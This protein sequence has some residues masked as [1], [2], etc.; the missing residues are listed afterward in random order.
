MFITGQTNNQATLTFSDGVNNDPVVL[1]ELFLNAASYTVPTKENATFIGYAYT[2][3]A[4]E[5]DISSTAQITYNTVKDH[6]AEGAVVLYP[7]FENVVYDLVVYVYLGNSSYN[8]QEE[9]FNALKAAFNAE[10]PDAKINW[11]SVYGVKNDVFC[12]N[13]T[14]GNADVMIGG[15]A[16]TNTF[17]EDYQKVILDTTSLFNDKTRYIGVVSGHED[18]ALAVAL[19]EYV[20]ATNPPATT[21][22][23]PETTPEG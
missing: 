5:A 20:L 1:S 10:K 14:N 21:P 11:V 18:N 13:A 7:V 3:N 15:K 9:E 23:E 12:S 22:E 2:E 4:T 16:M 19:Y 6:L 8:I 17:A